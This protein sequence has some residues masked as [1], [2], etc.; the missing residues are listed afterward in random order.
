VAGLA[1]GR[2]FGG[3]TPGP[4][5]VTHR[6]ETRIAALGG[7]GAAGA[8][9]FLAALA[10]FAVLTVRRLRGRRRVAD[11]GPADLGQ[12]DQGPAG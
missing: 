10:A 3:G 5:Q 4:I 9:G 6:D 12:P 11:Q 8:A 7:I 1:A 2:H